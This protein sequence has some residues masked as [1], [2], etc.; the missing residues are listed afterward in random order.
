MVLAAVLVIGQQGAALHVLSHYASEPPT[1]EHPQSPGGDA[2]EK[3]T[4]YAEVGSVLPAASYLLGL[5]RAAVA[6]LAPGALV[7]RAMALCGGAAAAL[8]R[9]PAP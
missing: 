2:C 7:V 1:K 3:C 9:G 8:R 5:A 4:A 6:D